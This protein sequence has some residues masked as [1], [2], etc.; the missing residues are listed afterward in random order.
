MK[1]LEE[2]RRLLLVQFMFAETEEE[3]DLI[4]EEMDELE[5]ITDI[6]NLNK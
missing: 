4:M 2:Y 3:G 1:E 5:L 6:L